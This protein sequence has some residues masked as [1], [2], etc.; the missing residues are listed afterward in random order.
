MKRILLPAIIAGI[1]VLTALLDVWT[2]AQ[3]AGSILFTFPLVLCVRQRSRW[4]LWSTAGIATLLSVAAGVW[5]FRRI[6]LVNPWIASLNR[7]LIIGSVLTLATLIHLWLSKSDQATLAGAETERN[8]NNLAAKNERLQNELAKIKGTG[9]GKPKTLVLTIKQ[10]HAL[11]GQLS[12]LHRTMAV[13]AMCTGLRVSEVLALKWDQVDFSSRRIYATPN[14]PVTELNRAAAKA[15]I[16][17]D[18]VLLETLLEWRNKSAGNGLIFPSHITGRCYHPGP[19]Q[20]DYFRP[21]ARK[22]GLTGLCWHTFPLS[23]RSWISEE[24]TAG[25]AQQKLLRHPNVSTLT[26]ADAPVKHRRKPNGKVVAS[27]GHAVSAQAT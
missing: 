13:A 3:L 12:D 15:G 8:I 4:L 7:G 9:K 22:L 24:G 27:T 23:Y 2:S 17:I 19:I 26:H 5:S 16:P 21:A 25:A 11:M 20:Q 6:E 14:D 1:A 10:Y 18:P